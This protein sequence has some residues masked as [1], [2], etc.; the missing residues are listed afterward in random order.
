MR[1]SNLCSK[2]KITVPIIA[3]KI[4]STI[5]RLEKEKSNK[6]AKLP[7]KEAR[8]I[9]GFVAISNFFWYIKTRK[10]KTKKKMLDAPIN[11]KEKTSRINP[12]MKAKAKIHSFLLI[13]ATLRRIKKTKG[14][15]VTVISSKKEIK[16]IKK[17]TIFI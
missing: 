16:K 1:L 10:M 11:L 4:A 2:E 13:T 9:K 15:V 6:N 7:K 12:K 8:K 5:I 17:T 14:R 3:L